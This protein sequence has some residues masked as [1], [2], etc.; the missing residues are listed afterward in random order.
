MLR[1]FLFCL[2]LLTCSIASS[3]KFEEVVVP[4]GATV[5]GIA[6][7]YNLDAKE[8]IR[9]NPGISV[10]GLRAGDRIKIPPSSFVKQLQEERD[11]FKIKS[12]ET[13]RDVSSLSQRLAEMQEAHD[14]D[15]FIIML[16]GL[17][18]VVL[19]FHYIVIVMKFLLRMAGGQKHYN[20]LRLPGEGRFLGRF[21]R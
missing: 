20:R 4:E 6:R 16:L 9:I 19:G 10:R 2:V 14:M 8:I 11:Q 13:R 12:E 5:D 1:L 18:S 3:A 15:L 7:F 17:I 21:L